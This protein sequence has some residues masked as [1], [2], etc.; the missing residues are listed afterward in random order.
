VLCGLVCASS[1]V[2][3]TAPAQR[4]APRSILFVGN[5]LTD[6]NDLPWLV[7]AL[8]D[9]AKLPPVRT[10][11]VIA[12]GASLLD[13]WIGGEALSRI[14]ER[15]D[16]VVMQQGPTSTASGRVELRLVASEF[17]DRIR[18]A[19]GQPALLMVWPQASNI[20]AFEDVSRS[21]RLAADDADAYLFPAGE[22]WL[23]TWRRNLAMPLYE[24]DLHPT[25]YGTYAAALTIVGQLYGRSVAGLPSTFQLTTGRRVFINPVDARVMQ[26]AA[27]V[28]NR[29][30]G[31]QP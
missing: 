11:F 9:S 1:C 21:Y 3:F 16:V 13:Q 18:K 4:P 8:I 6:A 22:T 19:G 29:R 31:R 25:T 27:D 14:D 20:G 30:F 12:P 10:G 2:D 7:G 17:A 15:W 23:E 28:V 24:D 26:D 5:S